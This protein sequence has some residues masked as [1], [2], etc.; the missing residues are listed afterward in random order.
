MLIHYLITGLGGAIGAMTRL[1]FS[2]LL[3]VEIIGI[4]VPIVAINILG[5]FVMGILAE[6]MAL[7]WSPSDNIRYFLITG[8]LGGF[9]TFSAF[10]LEFGLLVEKNALLQSAIYLSASVVLSILFF[11]FGMKIIRLF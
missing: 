10:A 4:P 5:C 11:F 8:F 2:R 9:T 6:I 1:L 7:Y 3:P